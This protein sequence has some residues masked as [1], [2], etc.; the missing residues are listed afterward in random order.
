MVLLL[1]TTVLPTRQP[2]EALDSEGSIL[3]IEEAAPMH[4]GETLDRGFWDN[5]IDGNRA[6]EDEI[7]EN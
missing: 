3:R 6:G 7:Q 1:D 5:T 4:V 2:V